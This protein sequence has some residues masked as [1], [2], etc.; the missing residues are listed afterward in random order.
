MDDAIGLIIALVLLTLL[1]GGIILP[2]VALVVSVRTRNRLNQQLARLQGAPLAPVESQGLS[3]ILRELTARVARL[4]AAVSQKP[5]VAP[6]SE[7]AKPEVEARPQPASPRPR[8]PV[9]SP[10]L[11]FESQSPPVSPLPTTK[12]ARTLNAQELES[13]IGR[14]WLGWAAVALILFATAFFLKYAFD[15][16]WIGELGRVAIGVTAGV[17]LAGLGYRYHKRKW[18]VFSQ[19]LTAGGVVLLYLSAYASFGY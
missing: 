5:A 2:I 3:Q 8:Q 14:R 15:N 1:V 16:R 7:A 12:P 10:P 18:R 4:E 19:I 17:T 9:D 13:I 6:P 11:S